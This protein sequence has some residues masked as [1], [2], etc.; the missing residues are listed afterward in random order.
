MSNFLRKLFR[1]VHESLTGRLVS[2]RFNLR[3]PIK[4]TIYPEIV[5]GKL[6]SAKRPSLSISGETVDLSKTGV[7]FMVSS[8]RLN[9]YYLVG[10]DRKLYA[11]IDLPTG[12][13]RMELVG[14]R[15]EQV[16]IHDS[17]SKFLIG[18]KIVNIDPKSKEIYE[19]FLQSGGK[20]KSKKQ[21]FS[22]EAKS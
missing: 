4:I 2:K 8:V 22:L 12:K 6:K 3:V 1:I 16:N 13:V 7:G 11:E 21:N 17:D 18:A 10:E 14:V 5:T 15:Y 19:E 9:E 20:A